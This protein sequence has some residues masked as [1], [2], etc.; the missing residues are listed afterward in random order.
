M[1]MTP[2]KF[3]SLCRVKAVID[4]M[5]ELIKAFKKL[6][7]EEYKLLITALEKSLEEKK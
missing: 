2:E 5:V 6:N 7:E 3:E 4:K 1:Q